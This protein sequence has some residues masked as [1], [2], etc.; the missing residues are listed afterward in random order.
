MTEGQSLCFELDAPVPP[1]QLNPSPPGA[2]PGQDMGPLEV[3]G[4]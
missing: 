2:V 3:I 1:K 4:S